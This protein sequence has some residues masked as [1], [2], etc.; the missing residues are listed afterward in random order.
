MLKHVLDGWS[1]KAGNYRL[2][3]LY[4]LVSTIERLMAV[5]RACNNCEMLKPLPGQSSIPCTVGEISAKGEDVGLC[6]EGEEG[7]RLLP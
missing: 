3:P 5:S 7:R 1:G 2:C 4:L 6:E